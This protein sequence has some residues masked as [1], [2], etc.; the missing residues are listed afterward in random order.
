[1]AKKATTK[2]TAS[3]RSS[4]PKPPSRIVKY[5]LSNKPSVESVKKVIAELQ[6]YVDEA[7]QREIEA[8]DAQMAALQEK[9]NKLQGGE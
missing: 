1:M 5:A 2:K 8:I 6:K 4:K 3:T 7:N 9:K